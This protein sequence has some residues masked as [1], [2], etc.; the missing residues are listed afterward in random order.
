MHFTAGDRSLFIFEQAKLKNAPKA[1]LNR[2][3]IKA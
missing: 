1:L 3:K 2:D